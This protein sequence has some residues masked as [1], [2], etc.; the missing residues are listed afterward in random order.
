MALTFWPRVTVCKKKGIR[1]QTLEGLRMMWCGWKMP[2]V[3]KGPVKR[4]VPRGERAGK[5]AD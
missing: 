4:E 2:S 1:E 3:Q 5:P